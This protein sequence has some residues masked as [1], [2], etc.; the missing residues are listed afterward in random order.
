MNSRCLTEKEIKAQAQRLGFVACG[1]A[2]AAPVEPLHARHYLQRIQLGHFAGM[3]YMTHHVDMRLDPSLLHPGLH[4][5]VSVA[6][7]YMPASQ[8]PAICLYAQ[9]QDYHEVMRE[10]M[11][12]LME[13][14]GAHGRCFVDTAPVMERYWA[15]RSGVGHFCRNGLISVP[16]Y[17]PTVFLG[18][19][20]LEE[21][22][23][24]YDAP[25]PSPHPFCQ[26]WQDLCP[27]LTPEGLDA[28]LC[29]NYWTI[30]HRGDLPD[31]IRLSRCFYG[32][33]RCMRACEEFRETRPCSLSALQPSPALMEMR[34]QDWRTLTPERFRSLFRHSAVK[35]AKYEG[36]M[37]NIS[38]WTPRQESEG[39]RE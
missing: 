30:E 8:Q 24:R 31:D 1:V 7:N 29:L 39:G 5:I 36:L 12:L 15:W 25:L 2:K 11:H 37:R 22:A 32:C 13:S 19:L 4:T 35:R 38:R 9:G 21:E 6:L 16:G 28:R 23:D 17:G 33:D 18:E 10:R 26:G 20:F 3:D 14:L 34:E 27:A